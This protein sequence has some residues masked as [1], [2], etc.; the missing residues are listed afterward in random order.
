MVKLLSAPPAGRLWMLPDLLAVADCCCL[1]CLLPLLPLPAT[2]SAVAGC[3]MLLLAA[4][5]GSCF[6]LLLAPAASCCWL[7]VLAYYGFRWWM[8][9]L[10][11][12]AGVC[13][14][15]TNLADKSMTV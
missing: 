4:A 9:L 6:R 14:T 1:L 15:T 13:K 7:F 10:L 3:C 2:L 5:A 12:D 8:P 11:T